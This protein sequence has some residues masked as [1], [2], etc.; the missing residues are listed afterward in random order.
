MLL[1]KFLT[2]LTIYYHQNSFYE[3]LNVK[4][5]K[6]DLELQEVIQH[7]YSI[8]VLEEKIEIIPILKKYTPIFKKY[9]FSPFMFD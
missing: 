2:Y 5:I 9:N 6:D 8:K 7:Y 1:K 3:L 4:E